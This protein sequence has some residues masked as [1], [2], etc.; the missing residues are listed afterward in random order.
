MPSQ[1]V[2]CVLCHNKSVS[3][4]LGQSKNLII[5]TELDRLCAKS[6]ALSMDGVTELSNPFRQFHKLYF[7][8]VLR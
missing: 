7:L 6:D 4:S 1:P 2:C 3:V 8:G 5:A